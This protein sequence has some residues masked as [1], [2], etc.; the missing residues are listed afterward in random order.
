M[1]GSESSADASRDDL[2]LSPVSPPRSIRRKLMVFVGAVVILTAASLV[3]LGILFAGRT[4]RDSARARLV[5]DAHQLARFARVWVDQQRESA[6]LLA[7]NT[8]IRR[9]L[10]E[11]ESQGMEPDA[12]ETAV[13]PILADARDSSENFLALH[14]TDPNGLVVAS[15]EDGMRGVDLSDDVAFLEGRTTRWVG[16][17]V[18]AGERWT[19]SIAAPTKWNDTLLGVVVV[20]V[21]VA[22]LHET[23]HTPLVEMRSLE[24][25]LATRYGDSVRFLAPVGRVETI[26]EAPITEFPV[27]AP[28]TSG[29]SGFMEGPDYLGTDVLAAY[30]PVGYRDW[31]LVT[32]V[33]VAEADAPVRMAAQLA[34]IVGGGTVIIALLCTWIIA[35]RITRPVEALAA[36]ARRL[37]RGNHR[38]RVRVRSRDEL[39]VLAHEFNRMADALVQAQERLEDRVDERTRELQARAREL[40]AANDRLQREITAKL[41][42][43]RGLE[44][45]QEDLRD[46][47]DVADAAN[48]AKS[49]FLANMS[50]EIRTPLNGIIGVAELLLATDL[51]PLQ[52]EYLEIVDKSADTLLRL[53]NDILDLSRI[54]AGKLV[55]EPVPFDV[56]DALSDPLQSLAAQAA[57]KGL[58]LAYHVDTEIPRRVRGDPARLCQVV[59]NL[60]GNAIKFTDKGEITVTAGFEDAHDGEVVVHFAV[61]DTGRGIPPKDRERIFDAFEQAHRAAVHGGSG[62]GLTIAARL[63]ALMGGRIWVESE[64]GKGTTVHFTA[65]FERAPETPALPAPVRHLGRVR[66]LAVDDNDVN[67][68]MLFETL[69]SWN[70]EPAVAASGRE[71]LAMIDQAHAE[72]RPFDLV[73]LDAVMPDLDG[74]TVAE[75]LRADARNEALVLMLLSSGPVA[76]PTASAPLRIARRLLKPVKRSEL[77][78]AIL[79]LF[80]LTDTHGHEPAGPPP[81]Q[82]PMHVLLAEDSEVNR[83]V[84]LD[85]LHRAGHHVDVATNGAEAVARWKEAFAA[86]QGGDHEAGYDVILMDVKMPRM[87]GFAA[88]AAIRK[89]EEGSGRRT[90]IVALTAHAMKGDR[91]AALAAGM[92]GYVTKPI[93][94]R[95][96]QRALGEVAAGASAEAPQPDVGPDRREALKQVGGDEGMLDELNAIFAEREG[97]RLVEGLRAATSE[98]DPST[99]RRHLHTLSSSL[100]ILGAKKTALRCAA[101][102]QRVVDEGAIAANSA[103]IEAIERDVETFADRLRDTTHRAAGES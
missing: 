67:R 49:E 42:A 69:R 81:E 3:V 18:L 21:A 35:D 48:R 78:E 40:E 4:L 19:S 10:W 17:P 72:G 70:I 101:L 90:P 64:M 85:M 25:L 102:E 80:D 13:R 24:V 63:V 11:L 54:E 39:G 53:L 47:R 12:L 77:L 60:V 16:D 91:E 30:A 83:R 26:R 93:R 32:K 92:D 2:V 100:T 71:A 57:V 56:A 38:A 73:L 51:S 14:L 27:L 33:D 99:L 84:A 68:R 45:S 22:P 6:G 28:A 89:E 59:T 15:T 8:A 5:Q 94:Q 79:E 88:T 74:F 62:L 43:Q 86:V 36:A 95:D 37:G 97:P 52:R 23:L 58:D 76:E 31:G 29:R 20:Q 66:A 98:R 65:Q 61:A 34:A 55:L 9:Y 82:T 87:D 103:E 75:R 46:A 44:R 1:N 7:D 96:L 50:H 41:D